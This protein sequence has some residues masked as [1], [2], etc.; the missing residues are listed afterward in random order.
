M[1]GPEGGLRGSGAGDG[2]GSGLGRSLRGRL[3]VSHAA[4]RELE[5]RHTVVLV[6]EHDDRGAVGVVLNRP[7]DPTVAEAVPP[8][9]GVVDPGSPLFEG[10][11][12]APEEPVLLVEADTPDVLD[13]PVFG[14]IGFMVGE[15]SEDLRTRLLRARVYAGH[16]GWGPGQLDSEV[17]A[18]AWILDDA[19]A[20]DVFTDTP[21][22][23]WSQVLERRGPEWAS[24]ARVPFDPTMN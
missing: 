19:R 18:G 8:L 17:E 21:E 13:V 6:G 14:S 9:A 1:T 3:L 2:S 20:E 23:L 22:L 10:G 5:F 4:L 24:M 15:V 7:L 12:V 11:P 16:A